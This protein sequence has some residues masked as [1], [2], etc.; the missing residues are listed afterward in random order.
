MPPPE[1]PTSLSRPLTKTEMMA[2]HPVRRD[3][4]VHDLILQAVS[5]DKAM[6]LKR[7]AAATDLTRPTVQKHLQGLVSEQRVIMIEERVGDIRVMTF[8]RA[9][10]IEKG[11]PKGEFVGRRNYGFFT[12]NS[13]DSQSV[14]VQ[15]REKDEVGNEQIKGAIAIDFEDLRNFLKE[16]FSFGNRV[17][18]K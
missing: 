13:G 6:T 4:Y 7:V 16:L 2:L 1:R 15:Q 5:E 9:G 18:L 12:I 3:R 17:V 14:I 11:G 10:K 8:K